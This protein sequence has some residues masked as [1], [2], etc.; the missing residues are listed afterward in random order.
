MVKVQADLFLTYV[1]VGC[2]LFTGEGDITLRPISGT[3]DY[4]GIGRGG[5]GSG[6]ERVDTGRG[7]T[8][9]TSSKACLDALEY[10]ESL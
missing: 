6:S 7:S 1:S 10:Q 3:T 4:R 9:A 5:N 2:V 8:A